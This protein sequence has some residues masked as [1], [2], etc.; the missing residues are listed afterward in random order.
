MLDAMA[1][2]PLPLL[3]QVFT[4]MQPLDNFGGLQHLALSRRV[5]RDVDQRWSR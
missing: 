1:Q 4:P 3:V 2:S 5:R